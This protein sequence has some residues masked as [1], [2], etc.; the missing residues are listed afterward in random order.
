LL[1]AGIILQEPQYIQVAT[2]TADALLTKQLRDGALLGEYGQ[3]WRPTVGW[4]C[5]TGNAQTATTWLKLYTLSVNKT[6][7]AAAKK[8]NAF[9][10]KTQNLRPKDLGVRREIRGSHPIQGGYLPY[11]YLN[12]VSKFFLDALVLE[13]TASVASDVSG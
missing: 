12:W 7:S 5:L 11:A 13:E 2:K 3:G 8:A 10:K 9:L 1:E 6:Y 4:T